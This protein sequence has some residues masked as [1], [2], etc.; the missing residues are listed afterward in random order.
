MVG[1]FKSLAVVALAWGC[2]SQ[3][4]GMNV[5]GGTGG[6]GRTS[7]GPAASGGMGGDTSSAPI[8]IG[9]ERCVRFAATGRG[10]AECATVALPLRNADP[11]SG[12]IE[13]FV[14]RLA[15]T[16]P[17]RSSPIRI[18]TGYS[19]ASVRRIYGVT[20]HSDTVEIREPVR[21]LTTR[22]QRRVA[23]F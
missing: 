5:S 15:A 23:A 2:S 18:R 22:R 1:S 3:P 21:P 11:D 20:S 17:R 19:E 9:F 4:L 10:E 16:K 7:A 13:V 8:D 14:R 12:S 6:A